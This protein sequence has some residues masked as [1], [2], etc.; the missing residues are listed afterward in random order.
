MRVIKNPTHIATSLNRD[1]TRVFFACFSKTLDSQ[2]PHKGFFGV[3]SENILS[4]CGVYGVLRCFSKDGDMSW[5]LKY[6][7][8]GVPSIRDA[9]SGPCYRGKS[10]N[11]SDFMWFV[12]GWRLGGS[13]VGARKACA[14]RAA[15][16]RAAGAQTPPLLRS[17]DKARAQQKRSS[18]GGG[19]F[20]APSLPRKGHRAAKPTLL[21]ALGTLRRQM[22]QI[23]MPSAHARVLYM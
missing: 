2:G 18:R 6:P 5:I 20:A 19:H 10:S 14:R 17:G 3:S 7:P 8:S 16:R 4:Q 22:T 21:G 15:L 1:R 11:C 13:C 12:R 9:K 23:L